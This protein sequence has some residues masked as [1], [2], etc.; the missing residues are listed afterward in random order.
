ML[1]A[2]LNR[3]GPRAFQAGRSR[4][5]RTIKKIC[6]ETFPL[7]ES[8]CAFRRLRFFRAIARDLCNF[9]ESA[10]SVEVL[11]SPRCSFSSSTEIYQGYRGRANH[12]FAKPWIYA[13]NSQKNSTLELIAP[14]AA[15]AASERAQRWRVCSARVDAQ[16]ATESACSGTR[17]DA[18]PDDASEAVPNENCLGGAP[19]NFI[20][21]PAN[22]ESRDGC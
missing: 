5:V 6:R 14:G 1:L 18:R 12:R 4:P 2:F 17:A 13:C 11:A 16:S 20:P 7:D 8:P 22:R 21:F 9:T 15:G 19:S 10:F 3:T